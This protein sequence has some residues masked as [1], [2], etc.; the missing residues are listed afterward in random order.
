MNKGALAR[1]KR[2]RETFVVRFWARVQK[3]ESCWEWQGG[4]NGGG[5]GSLKVEGRVELAHRVSYRLEVCEPGDICVLH[6]C[7]NPRCVRPDHLFLG[8]R[9]DNNRDRDQKGRLAPNYKS[10]NPN[11]RLNQADIDEIRRLY[12]KGDVRQVDL[13]LRFGVNQTHISRIVTNGAWVE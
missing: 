13:A 4:T 9:S 3:S 12:Q 11:A 10:R 8:T 2:I 6:S 1:A 5:Y 7:D